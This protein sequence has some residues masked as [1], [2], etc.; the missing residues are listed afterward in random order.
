MN[1]ADEA[2]AAVSRMS[3][4]RSLARRLG[5]QVRP[6]LLG[7]IFLTLLTGCA[8]PAV[9][10][11][12]AWWLFPGQA[13]G[14]LLTRGGAIVGSRLIGQNFTRPE[15]FHPRASAAGDGYDAFQSGGANLG[16][17]NPKLIA[18]VRQSAVDFRR[19]NGLAPYGSVPIDA[20]TTS[21]SG[22]DPDIS[23]E[24][25]MLQAAR[26]ARARRVDETLVRVLIADHTRGRSLGFLGAPRVSVL[27]LN[28]ALD[29]MSASHA[30]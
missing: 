30:P 13:D 15:Y 21:A 6:A 3:A 17:S 9:L 12:L 25:A 7:V 8:F 11:G 14:G 23:P 27:E 5:E 16:P 22:L 18:A 20:V 19:R 1:D 10:F 24:N 29:R 4:A 26:V 28:L 2:L